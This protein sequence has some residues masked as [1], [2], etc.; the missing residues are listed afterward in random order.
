LTDKDIA[1][2]VVAEGLDVRT[3][4]VSEVMTLDPI[5]V[6]DQGSRNEALNIMISRKFRHLPVIVAGDEQG[7]V[8]GLG[9]SLTG[10]VGGVLDI[11]KCVFERLED[12]E[13]KVIFLTPRL[14][15]K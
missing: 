8:S 9:A 1:F 4:P 5:A 7:Q 10:N 3:T 12:L 13:R 11:T 15:L 2:R 6:F 14:P